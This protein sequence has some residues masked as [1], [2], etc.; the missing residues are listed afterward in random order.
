[1]DAMK[2]AN[3]ELRSKASHVEHA[4]NNLTNTSNQVTTI[5]SPLEMAARHQV[6]SLSLIQDASLTQFL[7]VISKSFITAW[8]LSDSLKIIS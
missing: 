5:S 7:Q 2:A 3:L 6:W 4:S 8:T 1:M